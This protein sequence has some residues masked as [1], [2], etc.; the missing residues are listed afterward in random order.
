MGASAPSGLEGLPDLGCEGRTNLGGLTDAKLYRDGAAGAHAGIHGGFEAG[1]G[2]VDL[3]GQFPVLY[4]D[5][6]AHTEPARPRLDA[7]VG[8]GKPLQH[9]R[10]GDLCEAFG[11]LAR[12]EFDFDPG[13]HVATPFRPLHPRV[14]FREPQRHLARRVHGLQEAPHRGFDLVETRFALAVGPQVRSPSGQPVEGGTDPCGI[15]A[16]DDQPVAALA[17]ISGSERVVDERHVPRAGL[18]G[19][20]AIEFAHTQ[21]RPGGEVPGAHEDREPVGGRIVGLPRHLG[22]GE[23]HARGFEA[24]PSGQVDHGSGHSRSGDR[25]DGPAF[26]GNEV[27]IRVPVEAFDRVQLGQRKGGVGGRTPGAVGTGRPRFRRSDRDA[28]VR[29]APS[30]PHVE[31]MQVGDVQR[32]GAGGVGGFASQCGPQPFPHPRVADLHGHLRACDAGAGRVDHDSGEVH[33]CGVGVFVHEP[34]DG[35]GHFGPRCGVD[36]PDRGVPSRH[37]GRRGEESCCVVSH[38]GDSPERIC[39]RH[40]QVDDRALTRGERVSECA[41]VESRV[42]SGV[43]T[44]QHDGTP[45]TGSQ[46]RGAGQAQV[47][48]RGLEAESGREIGGGGGFA[49][50]RTRA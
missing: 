44:H 7:D 34:V 19:S 32:V 11:S 24:D 17:R 15:G 2:V 6:V 42:A 36:P 49:C 35:V 37:V 26:V 40:G 43:G 47:G 4:E 13:G 31:P 21:Q 20:K 48:G 41:D 33:P 8:L 10:A 3:P 22:E 45:G 23:P 50:I 39:D 5:G 29:A 46:G 30:D 38:E 9:D 18:V 25:Q 12:H 28:G 16:V 1:P 27:L 14:E